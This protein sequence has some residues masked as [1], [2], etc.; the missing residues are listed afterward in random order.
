MKMRNE[1][2][3]RLFNNSKSIPFDQNWSNGTGYYDQATRGE[4]APNLGYGEVVNSISPMP[5][6]RKIVIVGLG[7]E[8]GNLVFFERYTNGASDVIASNNP[9]LRRFPKEIQDALTSHVDE[10]DLIT[11]CKWLASD[12]YQREWS[13]YATR[14]E[15]LDSWSIV[16]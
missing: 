7:G 12:L 11:I 6:N 8:K 10:G 14:K 3:Y 4:Y 5:N 9:N 2:F 1:T 16:V 15:L 13:E